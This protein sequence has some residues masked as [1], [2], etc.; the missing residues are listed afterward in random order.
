MLIYQRV[1]YINI[2]LWLWMLRRSRSNLLS[3]GMRCGSR[4]A[5]RTTACRSHAWAIPRYSVWPWN[6][7]WCRLGAVGLWDTNIADIAFGYVWVM[8]EDYPALVSFL[9]EEFS[10][11]QWANRETTSHCLWDFRHPLWSRQWREYISLHVSVT[12]GWLSLWPIDS[13][14]VSWVF[15]H[16]LYPLVMTNIAIENGHL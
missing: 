11:G 2:M 8:V 16:R 1:T 15:F 12:Q 10:G 6:G 9:F 14:V 13:V 4:I 5:S 7:R 3:H